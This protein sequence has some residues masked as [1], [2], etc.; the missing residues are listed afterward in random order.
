ML[1]GA[2]ISTW[3]Q[4][5]ASHGGGRAS[6]LP[7]L[8]PRGF[9][10]QQ[11]LLGRPGNPRANRKNSRSSHE[12]NE[13]EREGE[14]RRW[15]PGRVAATRAMEPASFLCLFLFIFFCQISDYDKCVQMAS[16]SLA[17]LAQS[18][19]LT[20]TQRFSC[21]ENALPAWRLEDPAGGLLGTSLDSVTM[22]PRSDTGAPDIGGRWA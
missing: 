11:E 15:G 8:C 7:F 1:P 17:H 10:H 18:K 6:R 2:H 14:D 19:P 12:G 9:F 13:Q 22:D 3:G 5:P 4:S 20:Q 21:S 16:W